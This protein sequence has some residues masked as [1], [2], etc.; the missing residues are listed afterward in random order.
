MNIG[1]CDGLVKTITTTRP[2]STALASAFSPG[3]R[4]CIT[5]ASGP[6]RIRK[7]RATRKRSGCP[8][9]VPCASKPSSGRPRGRP[10]SRLETT[11]RPPAADQP[12]P[13][14][15][16]TC[17]TASPRPATSR[18]RPAKR[19]CPSTEGAACDQPISITPARSGRSA[20]QGSS[21]R[22]NEAEVAANDAPAASAVHFCERRGPAGDAGVAA[23]ADRQYA[24]HP[25]VTSAKASTNPARRR[26]KG[27]QRASWSRSSGTKAESCSKQ[28]RPTHTSSRRRRIRGMLM[29]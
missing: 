10:S 1:V 2:A 18:A 13:W 26:R 19:R 24:R 15:P 23:P 20:R 6:R 16:P 22:R 11:S 7:G 8:V 21:A 3:L 28:L 9:P 14:P 29:Y 5:T 25:Q 12:C 4:C 17:R 27:P